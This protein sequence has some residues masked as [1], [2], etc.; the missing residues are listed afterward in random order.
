MS[1]INLGKKIKEY[2]K[3]NNITQQELANKLGISRSTLSYY[4]NGE[5]EPNIYTL[6]KLSEIMNCSMDY[7]FSIEVLDN[8]DVK[9]DYSSYINNNEKTINTPKNNYV[10]E[11]KKLLK[12]ADIVYDPSNIYY[13]DHEIGEGQLFI[14][15]NDYIWYII[16]NG[17]EDDDYSINNIKT[18]GPGAVGFRVPYNDE[19]HELIKIF[20]NENI[21]KGS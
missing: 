4:E 11:L 9:I 17:R 10:D 2:R 20:S 14:I 7:L 12:K 5:V 21:Y 19:L 13:E 6:L 3:L 16:N 1:W 18:S 15:N 8:T